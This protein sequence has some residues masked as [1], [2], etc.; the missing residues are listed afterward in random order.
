MDVVVD[1][2]YLDRLCGCLTIDLDP[3]STQSSGP[4]LIG[5]MLNANGPKGAKEGRA[6]VKWRRQV[7]LPPLRTCLTQNSVS[8]FDYGQSKRRRTSLSL[9]EP[10]QGRR[11][12]WTGI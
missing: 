6:E 2:E 10:V 4:N 11:L 1:Q 5:V 3:V 9:A 7:S 8:N 12:L